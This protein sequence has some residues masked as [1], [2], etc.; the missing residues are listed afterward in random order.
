MTRF[1]RFERTLLRRL[2]FNSIYCFI[3]FIGMPLVFVY[4]SDFI[5]GWPTSSVGEMLPYTLNISLI[6]A[7]FGTLGEELLDLKREVERL[8]LVDN[9][10]S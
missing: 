1:D 3:A 5:F 8:K 6:T 10:E 9:R 7:V 2:W 4:A